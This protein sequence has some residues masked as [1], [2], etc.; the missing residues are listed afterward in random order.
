M[1][2]INKLRQLLKDDDLIIAPGA[3]DALT[4]RLIVDAALQSSTPPA[5]AYRTRSLGLPTSAS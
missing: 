4:A 3:Y 1:S 5:P 2:A